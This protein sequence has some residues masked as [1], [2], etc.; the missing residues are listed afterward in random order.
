[1]MEKAAGNSEAALEGGPEEGFKR[2]SGFRT[3]KEPIPGYFAKEWKYR[4]Y[5]RPHKVVTTYCAYSQR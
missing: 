4:L 2:Y 5:T 1:M 3:W